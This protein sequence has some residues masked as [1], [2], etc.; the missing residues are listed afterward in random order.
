MLQLRA[1]YLNGDFDDYWDYHIL[2][3]QREIYLLGLST[4][5]SEN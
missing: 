5:V 1:T 2:Q 4:P 3:E